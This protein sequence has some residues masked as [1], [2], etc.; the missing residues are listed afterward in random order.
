ME[1]LSERGNVIHGDISINNILINH[2]WEYSVKDSP[3]R[4]R[5]LASGVKT[6]TTLPEGTPL[7]DNTHN[8]DTLVFIEADDHNDKNDNNSMP[9][10]GLGSPHGQPGPSSS[11]I[12]GVP[13]LPLALALA[14]VEAGYNG[15]LEHI[16]AT[17]MLI[18]CDF[19][20]YKDVGSHQTSVCVLRMFS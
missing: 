13:I 2:V 3:S 8:Q 4:L 11:I 10:L 1:F 18:D 9:K 14:P 16:E 12:K 19:M 6:S 20:R 5:A 15:T 17:G 7:V